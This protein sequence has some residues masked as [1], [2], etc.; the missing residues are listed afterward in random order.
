MIIFAA[1]LLI[2]TLAFSSSPLLAAKSGNHLFSQSSGKHSASAS[3]TK[4]STPKKGKIKRSAATI[5]GFK[6]SHPCPANGKQSGPCKGYVIDHIN[7]LA[8]GGA[9]APENMQ[10]QT[11]AEAIAKDKWE[12]KGSSESYFLKNLLPPRR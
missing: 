9:D 4:S 7:P 10:W 5:A 12:R 11:K 6:Y 2:P 8:C 3:K 1:S